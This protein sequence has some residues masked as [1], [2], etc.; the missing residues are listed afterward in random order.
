MGTATKKIRA[1]AMKGGETKGP[2]GGGRG[3]IHGNSSMRLKGRS[4]VRDV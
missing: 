2:L 3:G 1:G 4:Y